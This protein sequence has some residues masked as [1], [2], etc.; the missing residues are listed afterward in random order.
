MNDALTI[1]FTL[2]SYALIGIIR[3]RLKRN[4]LGP[5]PQL[6]LDRLINTISTGITNPIPDHQQDE[7]FQD[8]QFVV[9]TYIAELHS[10]IGEEN[11]EQ[12]IKTTKNGNKEEASKSRLE[13]GQTNTTSSLRG[14]Q[15]SHR[16]RDGCYNY[17]RRVKN[18]S[19]ARDISRQRQSHLA[20]VR[21]SR[22]PEEVDQTH[23]SEHSSGHRD[24]ELQG[25]HQKGPET[26]ENEK[27]DIDLDKTKLG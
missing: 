1:I 22:I 19:T 15:T 20:S 18:Q 4:K 25:R 5:I 11:D 8:I 13:R 7:F 21:R 12:K 23:C 3:D 26:N 10:A 9:D 14:Q 17:L 24:H 2:V 27:R 6:F 16:I